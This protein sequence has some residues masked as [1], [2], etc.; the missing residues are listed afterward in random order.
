MLLGL[1]RKG[2]DVDADSGHVGV[3]LVGLDQ[4]EVGTLATRESVVAVELEQ[5]IDGGVV[6]SHALD[7]GDGVPRLQD[8]A[9]PEVGV[10]EGLLSLV[11][12]HDSVVAGHE[13]VTLDNPDEFLARVVEVELQLVGGG[14]DGL[15]AGELEHV[16]QVLVRHL[17]ELAALIRVQVDVVNVQGR[18]GQAS[19][20]DTV[21]DGV[22]VGARALVPAQ[23]VQ[24]VELEVKANLVVLERNQG[25]RETRVAAEPE[26]ERHVQG[27]HGGA[28]ANLLRGVGGAGVARVVAG[29]TAG[30][31][32]VGQLRHVA[33]HHG[34]TS[35]LASLLG[36]FV[37]DV[38]PVAIVL[39]DA[40][41]ANLELD[42]RDEVLANPVEPSELA[43]GA[44][45]GR[46]DSDLRQ[47][48][49]E[50]NTVDQVAVALN[51]ASHLL[52][53]VGGTIEGVLN[54]L[55]RKVGV[56][57]VDYLKKG[58]L[59][60]TCEVNILGAVGHELHQTTTCHLY[61]LT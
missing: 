41:A 46:I 9:V 17:G 5:R 47:G 23:V 43:V 39:V 36:E 35:L 60:V 44:V 53:K 15:T 49:L 20:G 37:P 28:G 6:A 19:L 42:I 32:Q 40:L 38:E 18:S 56:A 8:G 57:T 16:N 31:N 12:A 10:V 51:S 26:L 27:V 24:G 3:V 52:A 33:N 50:V 34:I 14:G 61:T 21:A 58:D 11:G 22:G 45:R 59:G 54:G 2:V 29:D 13:G 4:V 25:Q 55:H 1:E 7:A 48:G 30:H